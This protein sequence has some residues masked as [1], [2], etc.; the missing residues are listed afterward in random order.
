M[1][2]P[3][4][5]SKRNVKSNVAWRDQTGDSVQEGHQKLRK[6]GNLFFNQRRGPICIKKIQC[7]DK[8]IVEKTDEL[9]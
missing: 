3:S 5:R 4:G 1:L 2:H 8:S 7:S 9:I 6:T